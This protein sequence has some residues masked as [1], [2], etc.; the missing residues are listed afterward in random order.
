MTCTKQESRRQLY[1]FSLLPLLYS[2]EGDHSTLVG[3]V[4]PQHVQDHL[5]G[6]HAIIID[7]LMIRFGIAA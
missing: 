6:K 2:Q 4:I 7:Q 1:C 3:S 5:I